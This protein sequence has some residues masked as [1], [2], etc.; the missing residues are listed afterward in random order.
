[1]FRFKLYYDYVTLWFILQGS[2]DN[3]SIIIVC[4]SG[5]PQVTP[6]ALQQEAELE[7]LLDLKVEGYFLLEFLN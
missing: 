3:M 4:F 5:A 7:Q 2:L 6:K 1:M